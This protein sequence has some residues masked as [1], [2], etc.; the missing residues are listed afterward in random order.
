MQIP[1]LNIDG[2]VSGAGI[3]MATGALAVPVNVRRLGWWRD[4]A[5]PGDRRGTT[6][7]GGHVDSATQGN[8]AFKRLAASRVGTRIRVTTGDGKI[9]TYRVTSVR[10]ILKASLP[11]GLFTQRGKRRLVLVTCGGPFQPALGH[12]RDNIVVVAVPL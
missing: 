1:S 4:G 3:D 12:Y 7:I 10:R 8:G 9:R 6:L 11:A 5:A 2:P